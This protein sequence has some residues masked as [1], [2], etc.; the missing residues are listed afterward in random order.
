MFNFNR[1]TDICNIV[2]WEIS[3]I[4]LHKPLWTHWNSVGSRD[5]WSP[6]TGRGRKD[7]WLEPLKGLQH[8]EN[9]TSDMW[10]PGLRGHASVKAGGEGD[11]RGWDGCMVS[12]TQWTWVWDGEEQGS[13]LCCSPWSC[14]VSPARV[15]EQQS[16]P[17]HCSCGPSAS[18]ERSSWWRSGVRYSVL[19]RE[20]ISRT[21]LQIVRYFQKKIQILASSHI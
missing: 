15:S 19:R 16:L 4:K 17:L 14:R 8:W 9:L 11:D 10:S 6:K 21:G 1:S 13:L 5:A 7:P 18:P 2:Q 3:S 20:I 12:P